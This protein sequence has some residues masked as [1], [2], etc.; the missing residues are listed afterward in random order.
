MEPVLIGKVK[1]IEP[2]KL[3]QLK[4]VCH[5][6]RFNEHHHLP[7]PRGISFPSSSISLHKWF[8]RNGPLSRGSLGDY[9]HGSTGAWLS[10][11]T[12]DHALPCFGYFWSE[13]CSLYPFEIRLTPTGR[14]GTGCPSF[15]AENGD[16]QIWPVGI[17]VGLFYWINLKFWERNRHF[18][19]ETCLFPW[20]WRW[21]LPKS[22]LWSLRESELSF[23]KR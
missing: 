14:I 21:S 9:D 8:S 15:V 5:F 4:N 7:S 23:L 3:F 19:H 11:T 22:G 12:A 13:V 18:W 6:Q 20:T 10:R 17:N 16:S 1:R 2:Y